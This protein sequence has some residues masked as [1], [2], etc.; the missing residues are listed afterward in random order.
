MEKEHCGLDV[1]KRCLDRGK[2]VLLLCAHYGHWEILGLYHGFL[3]ISPLYSIVRHLDNPYLDNAVRDFRTISGSSVIFK[4]ESLL[5][6]VRVLKNNCCV[7]IMMD[8]NTRRG[9]I[10]VNFFGKKAATARSLALL[11]HRTGA[12]IVPLISYPTRNGTYEIQ[13][14]PELR[15]ERTGDKEADI[16]NWTSECGRFIEDVIKKRPEHW[17]WGHRRWRTR[18]PE[19]PRVRIYS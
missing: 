8:Q 5:K 16:S 9:R 7:L 19:E 15:L 11:S 12:A 18:P 3:G 2:G 4:E 14:G 6:I 10:F 1:L 17:M 13:Y